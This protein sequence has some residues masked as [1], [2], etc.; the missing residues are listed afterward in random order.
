M[1]ILSFPRLNFKGV[2]STNPCT[3]NND[4]VLPNVVSR[5]ADTFGDNPIFL[6]SDTKVQ[7]YMNEMVALTN[8][9]GETPTGK[10]I[11]FMRS[12]WNLYGNHAT[13]F[14]NTVITSAVVGPN[15]NQRLTSP[16][17][18]PIIGQEFR[19]LGSPTEDPN[20][21][22]T[23][24]IVDLDSTGLITTQLFIGGIQFGDIQNPSLTID[25]DTRAYQDWLN[26]FSTVGPYFGEQNFVGIGCMMQFAI[27]PSALSSAAPTQQ[28]RCHL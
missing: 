21:R 27:P 2:F 25:S 17:Q 10:P 20:R 14:E 3:N 1:S 22:G 15:P 9:G 24:M 16:S 26:F 6:Q 8:Y 19:I 23:P 12:G 5:D 11:N 28:S 18:D 4:D 7:E 13:F